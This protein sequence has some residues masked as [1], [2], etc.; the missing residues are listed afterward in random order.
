MTSSLNW[1]RR[2]T[3]LGLGAVPLGL[4][5]C[6]TMDP[7]ILEGI[8]GAGLGGLTQGDAALGIR[9]A[10]DN[11][12][13]SALGIV[14]RSGGFFNDGQIHIPLPKVLQDVQSVMSQ[15]GAGSLL[16]EL[17]V[18]LNRGAEIAA[19]VAK[20]I[21]LDA[22]RG[23]TIQDAIAIV[24]GNNT[25]ATQYLADKTIP[26]LTGLFTPIME[27]ALGQTGAL[28]LLDQATSSLRNIPFA[29]KL[30][31]DART[32]LIAH[33]VSLGLDGVFHYIAKEEMAIR[34]NPAKRSSEI[35]RRV[36]GA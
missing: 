20:N 10:L 8:L 15:I 9:A 1:N 35:L 27:K 17:E 23:L 22:V 24:R 6:E 34:A 26:N 13:L 33:G 32:D 30:G 36:F 25:A 29:P 19:P 11:G 5:A 2:Q 21:F 7:A 4:S 14:G 3:L 18:Q 31:A 28:K 16:N 12:V